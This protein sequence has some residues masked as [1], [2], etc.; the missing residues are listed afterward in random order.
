MNASA[1]HSAVRSI[2][3]AQLPL[4]RPRTAGTRTAPEL[5][6]A[7]VFND[8][9][10]ARLA[11]RCST[12]L[13]RRSTRGVSSN[14]LIADAVANAMKD[15]A[16][17]RGATHFTH[18]FQPMTGLTAQKHDA[19]IHQTADGRA[20]LVFSGKELIK[21]EPDASSFPSGGIRATFEARGYTAWDPTSPAFL[22]QT[23]WGSTLMIPTA[24][25]SWTGEALDK[26]TPLLRSCEAID[27]QAVRLLHLLGEKNVT[28]VYP[29]T[30]PEQG[31]S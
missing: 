8:A 19:F 21:G 5:F 27:R 13:R 23:P 20:L 6:G 7:N 29:T 26:K 1:R 25:C 14:P 2:S 24:F 28:K 10:R 18:W 17:E 16:V 31:T 4:R 9:V 3:T 12:A 22:R 11:T 15:W 30:G